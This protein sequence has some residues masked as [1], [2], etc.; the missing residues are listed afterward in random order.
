MHRWDSTAYFARVI[1]DLL[2]MLMKSTHRDEIRVQMPAKNVSSIEIIMFAVY[3]P[4]SWF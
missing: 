2:K 1:K 4:H 3:G